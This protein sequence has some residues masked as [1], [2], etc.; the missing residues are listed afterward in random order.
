MRTNITTSAIVPYKPKQQKKKKPNVVSRNNQVTLSQ[1]EY[2]R[3]LSRPKQSTLRRDCGSRG[4]RGNPYLQTLMNPVDV[5]GVKVPD[6]S[7][8]PTATLQLYD[9]AEVTL[10][11]GQPYGFCWSPYV[12]SW[13]STTT[14]MGVAAWS[15][16][17]SY[18]TYSTLN[19]LYHSYRPVSGLVRVSSISSTTNNA[20]E[21]AFCLVAPGENFGTSLTS[22]DAVARRFGAYRCPLK[23]SSEFLWMP[24]DPVSRTFYIM[25]QQN[26]STGVM[27]NW[28][29]IALAI[30]GAATGQSIAIE[31]VLNCELLPEQSNLNLTQSSAPYISNDDLEEAT[32]VMTKLGSFGRSVGEN[33]GAWVLDQAGVAAGRLGAAAAGG[34]VHY[35]SAVLR[36]HSMGSR[37]ASHYLDLD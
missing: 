22:F 10:T 17:N 3:L 7:S 14:N 11:A 29:G 35:A 25:A 28:P 34:A 9:R 24:L 4:Q 18:A 32:G 33:F 6:V 23:E 2:S 27:T 5:T 30:G 37:R 13:T 8:Y 12:N 19:T 26:S 15:A 1:K 21:L 36:N 20:G 16:W 31:W